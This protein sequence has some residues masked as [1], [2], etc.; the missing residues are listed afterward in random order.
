MTR[1][2]GGVRLVDNHAASASPLAGIRIV[3][4]GN[5][6]AVPIAAALMADMGAEVIKVEPPAGDTTRNMRTRGLGPPVPDHSFHALNRGKRSITIDLARPGASE[7]VLRLIESADIFVTN[8]MTERLERYGLTYDAVRSRATAIIFA[9]LTGWGSHGPGATRPGFDSTSFWAGS[10]LMAL[11]GEAGTPAVVSRGGQGDYPAGLMLT[12]AL[13]AALRVRDQT[14]ESQF[15]DATLQRAGLWSLAS[16][17][18]QVLNSPGYRPERFDRVKAD[19]ATRNSYETADGRWLMLTMHNI[20]YWKAFCKALGRTDWADDPRYVSPDLMPQNQAELI[21]EIDA[22][23]RSHDYAYWA[24]RLDEC[25][26]VWAVA[27]TMEEVASDPALREQGT[28]YPI[29]N[30]DEAGHSVE[31]VTIPF[32]IAGAE[33]RPRSRAPRLGE[34]SHELLMEAGFNEEEIS[35]IASEGILG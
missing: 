7:I 5:F 9:Q 17:A 2:P 33:M 18:Q 21:P 11:M 24:R 10:G 32:T 26:C 29:P 4:I 6:L 28:F 12:T 1:L 25:G 34:H 16:E 35:R 3:E 19:L 14:G 8:L 31:V 13:L 20:L 15:V 22:I 27:A 30:V 23:F